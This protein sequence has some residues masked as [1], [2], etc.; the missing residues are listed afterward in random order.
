MRRL[1]GSPR[2]S[3]VVRSVVELAHAHGLQ[4]TAE[5]VETAEQARL[6]RQ[7]GCDHAQGWLFG[8]PE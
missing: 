8:R 5:G 4:V 1:D 3:A 2:P 6:L 7:M